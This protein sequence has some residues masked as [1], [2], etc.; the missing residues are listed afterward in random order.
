VDVVDMRAPA[1]DRAAKHDAPPAPSDILPD[2][3]AALRDRLAKGEQSILLL[4][5]RGYASFI[6]CGECG[7]VVVCPTCAISLTYHRTP[8]RLVC[9]YCE[10][11]DTPRSR[12]GKCSGVLM[13]QR[14]FGTQQ[15]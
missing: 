7:T 3:E 14:G 12:C 5:R 11:S 13:R 15:V 6:Q 4:N 9:H 2:L 8:E 10:H 1:D